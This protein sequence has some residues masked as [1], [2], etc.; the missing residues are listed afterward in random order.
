[1]PTQL[2]G[3][4]VSQV[5]S[6]SAAIVARP[7]SPRPDTTPSSLFARGQ[8]RAGEPILV[9]TLRVAGVD[10]VVG[11]AMTLVV[12][13]ALTQSPDLSL[14]AEDR[15]QSALQRMRLSPATT[16]DLSTGREI[17]RRENVR[18]VLAG[19]V[20]RT[21]KTFDVGLRLVSADSGRD[22]VILHAPVRQ[23]DDV[24][25]RLD[26]LT[27]QLRARIGEALASIR[28]S[29][30]LPDVTTRSLH[31]LELFDQHFRETD[32]QKALALLRAAV[33][34]DSEFAQAWRRIWVHYNNN[35]PFGPERDSAAIRTRRYSSRLPRKEQLW[36][37]SF[38]NM[39][40]RLF[41]DADRNLG[42]LASEQL[43]AMGDSAALINTADWLNT[44]REFARAES[45]DIGNLR[46]FPAPET[47]SNLVHRRLELGR[48]AEAEAT[49]DS[50]LRAFPDR[51]PLQWWKIRMSLFREDY[52]TF[53]RA[54]DSLVQLPD[55]TRRRIASH[56]RAQMALLHG[57][58]REW[59]RILGEGLPS[60]GAG[61]SASFGTELDIAD[62]SLDF[63][64]DT[65]TALRHA[66][67]AAQL[68]PAMSPQ[69]VSR[70]GR[71]L[72][73]IGRPDLARQ[74]LA[75]HQSSMRDTIR[76]RKTEFFEHSLMA[77]ILIAENRGREA[78]DE[79][80][81]GDVS[82]RR[83]GASVLHLLLS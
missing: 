80:R 32:P 81:R 82:A 59:E 37:E 76:R 43:A 44:R 6:K 53:Q 24:I 29:R 64:R 83:S 73:A 40:A 79:V 56:A 30:P 42:I 63:R 16:I 35:G 55:P 77:E 58:L 68:D 13:A 14:L 47:W 20:V 27:R 70:L 11:S 78:I 26:T 38:V 15:I 39:D 54:I 62:I 69:A 41:P 50:A 21:G 12:R 3:A 18:V 65:A 36:V 52:D 66:L 49:A 48:V 51:W 4:A 45:L 23:L 9:T 71:T 1:M 28:T 8:L 10:S 61:F 19:H 22:L 34:A 31:A 33:A 46:R 17:A 7:A 5:R 2:A 60:S 75:E 57:R 74:R 25:P 72:A 67:A